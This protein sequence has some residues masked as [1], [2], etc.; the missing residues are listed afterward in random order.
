MTLLNPLVMFTNQ[1]KKRLKIYFF[2]Q[3]ELSTATLV[4]KPSLRNFKNSYLNKN[5]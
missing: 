5:Q 2:S 1:K 4:G 3:K